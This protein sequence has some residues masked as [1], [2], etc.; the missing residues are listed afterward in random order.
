MAPFSPR[1]TARTRAGSTCITPRT[2][3]ACV[4]AWGGAQ[5]HLHRCGVALAREGLLVA[6]SRLLPRGLRRRGPRVVRVARPHARDVPHPE[7]GRRR[8]AR[9]A[10]RGARA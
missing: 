6:R 9:V 1:C 4:L 3:P 2:T 5:G 8:A 7:A 10:E